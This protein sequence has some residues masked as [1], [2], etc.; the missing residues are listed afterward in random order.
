MGCDSSK[1]TYRTTKP[2]GTFHYF[3]AYAR[4]EQ[5]RLL[6]N[7]ADVNFVDKRIEM[8]D[9]PVLKTSGFYPGD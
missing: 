3:N 9:W 6:L 8:S 1:A 2:V 5:I 7:H 4:G